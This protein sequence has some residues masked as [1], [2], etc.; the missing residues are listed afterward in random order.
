LNI[1]RRVISFHLDALEK[2]GL[3]KSEFGE[4]KTQGH[5]QLDFMP[6]HLREKIYLK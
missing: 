2:V 6:L 4:A 1:P 3:V 5:K